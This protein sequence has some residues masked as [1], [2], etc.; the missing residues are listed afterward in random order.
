MIRNIT[1]LVLGLLLSIVSINALA[2]PMEL[3]FTTTTANTTIELPLF[4]TV[5]CTVDWDDLTADGIYTTAGLKSHTF[6]TV[7]TYTV[8]ISGTLTQFGNGS[9][10]WTGVEYLTSVSDFGNTGLTSLEGAFNNA[11]NLLS[12]PTTLPSTITNLKNLF[13]SIDQ[14]SIT[15]LDLWVVSNVEDM[16]FMFKSASAFN[17]N[18]GNWDVSS[19]INMNGMFALASSFNQDISEWDVSSVT[20]MGSMFYAASSFN[21]D[22]SE[23]IV[24]SVT[25]MEYMFYEASSFNQDIS[26][27]DVSS[28]T[29]M[30]FMFCLL[31]TSPS[32]RDVE[33]SRMPSSA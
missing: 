31:Y 5:N 19:V 26:N 8:S 20:W 18:I 9:T 30:M 4:G 21:Q 16:S 33:E 25:N 12:V 32:P 10:P 29:D 15:N 2:A 24:S 28:V 6:A 27:W 3:V 23:W 14:E 22:I 13:S 17:Q 7:G 11:D 1:H